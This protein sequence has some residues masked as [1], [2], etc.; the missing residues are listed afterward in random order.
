MSTL[1]GN[2]IR[3]QWVTLPGRALQYTTTVTSDAYQF[4]TAGTGL[5][6]PIADFYLTEAYALPYRGCW[7]GVSGCNREYVFGSLHIDVG[8]EL[9]FDVFPATLAEFVDFET[10][11]DGAITNTVSFDVQRDW[12]NDG[13]IVDQLGGDLGQ[14]A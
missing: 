14:E 9:L 10:W 12:D 13:L 7:L 1:K 6:R 3:E 11:T 4:A 2:S 8:E 5:N